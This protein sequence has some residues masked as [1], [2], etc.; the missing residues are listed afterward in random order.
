MGGE[1][2]GIRMCI[3]LFEEE[4]E[5]EEYVSEDGSFSSVHSQVTSQPAAAQHT[6]G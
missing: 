3:E 4:E 6:T 1:E 5:E 2:E